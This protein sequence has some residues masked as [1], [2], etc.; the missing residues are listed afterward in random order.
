MNF[1]HLHLHSEYSLLD[2]ACRIADIPKAARAAGHTAV[3]ITDHGALYGAAAFYK[4]C[5]HEK[6]KP[7]IGCEV[8]VAPRTRFD[9]EGRR[10]ASGNHLVLLCENKKGYENLIYMVSKS[11]TEGFYQKPR[12]DLELLRTH[13]EGL[14]ALSACL[15]GFIP[16]AILSGDYSG[17]RAHACALE[18]IFG[19]GNFFLELQQHGLAGQT[20][21]NGELIRMSEELGIPLVATNDVHYLRKLDAEHQA[22]MM[23]IQTGNVLSDGKPIGFETDE[24]YYKT[25]AEME[26]L[27]AFAPSALENTGKI[28]ER[29]LFAFEF[30]NLYLPKLD[31]GEQTPAQRLRKL[32]FDGLEKKIQ[33]K[34]IVFDRYTKE[35]YQRRAEYEL[36]VI[37]KMGFTD[38]ILIVQDYV[39]YAKSHGIAVGPGR[40]SGAGSLV[41]YLIGITDV[42]SIRFELLFERFLNP[43]RVSMPDIDVDFCYERRDEVLAYVS[44]HYGA[45]HVAQIIT[46]GTMAARAAIRDVGRALGMSY[47]EVD[48]VAGLV[49]RGPGVTLKDA[50][51]GKELKKLYESDANIARLIDIARALEG[52]PRHASTHAAGVVITDRAVSDYVPLAVNGDTVVTQYD[53]DTV[54]EIGL[55]KFDFLGLRYLTIIADAEKLIRQDNPAFDIQKIPFDD[56]KTYA[57]ISAGQTDG[58]FQLESAGMK[59]VLTQL[60][61][62]CIEDIIAVLAL[63]RPGPM[64]SI[65]QYIERRHGRE[66]VEYHNPALERI[67]SNTYGCIVYQEQVMQIFREIAGYSLGRAD[68]VRR[69]M[70]KKKNSVMEAERPVFISG[71]GQRGMDAGE[72]DALFEDMASFASYAFNKSHA[73]SYAVLTYQTAFLKAHYM[74]AYMAALLTSVLGDFGK[75]AEYIAECAKAKIKVLPPDINESITV[76]GARG[77]HIRFGLLALKGVGRQFVDQIIAERTARGKFAS[78]E[79]F[80]TRMG[81]SDLNKRQVEAL[82]KSGAFDGLGVYR[83]QLLA[84]YEKIIENAQMKNRFEI[85]GQFD[86]FSMTDSGAA[87]PVKFDYPNIPEFTLKEKLMLEKES[88]GMYF[89]GHLLNDYA[90]HIESLHTDRIA[91]ILSSFEEENSEGYRDKQSVCV[92]AMVSRKSVKSTR[93]GTNMA[94]VTLEDKTGEIEAVVF[95][96]QYLQFADLLL[97]ETPVA[98]YGTISARDEEKPKLILN[99]VQRL[100]SNKNFLAAEKSLYLRVFSVDTPEAAQAVALLRQNSGDTPVLFYEMKNKR[101]VKASGIRAHVTEALLNQLT[102]LVGRQNVVIQ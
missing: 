90:H 95:S 26:K 52:M 42:D 82:I 33:D 80:I 31:T 1:V 12:V 58:V 4:A 89:S 35:D 94:F 27:F 7:I 54:A 88:S 22:V 81:S 24:F 61:P 51:C 11:Y 40:G 72:A 28:A 6:I 73:V 32:A 43:E 70:S 101:Y 13:A 2:G 8:Y 59:R 55:V 66:T 79:D 30:G 49:P 20:E 74:S 92:A 25:T 36:D 45:D 17:A 102:T 97:L 68:I 60:A 19:K 57:L 21:V 65:P 29:C 14:I 86:I 98:V 3:A 38:Y 56:K 91:D 76:F 96:K 83:S 85:E 46:F 87:A 16:K 18:E 41:N 75:T 53:M 84:S 99:T 37:E 48:A 39:A 63:Y 93:N 47:A 15:G 78:F 23:C 9:K 34:Y 64:D 77:N 50:L 71:A 69:A 44:E 10:D 5:V 100:I 62:D 67:L